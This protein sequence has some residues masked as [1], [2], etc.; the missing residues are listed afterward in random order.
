MINTDITNLILINL[1]VQKFVECS[2]ISKLFYKA[3]NNQYMW[4]KKLIHD[5]GYKG[6]FTIYKKYY[7][8]YT[9]SN[10]QL[11]FDCFRN[12]KIY[13]RIPQITSDTKYITK[14]YN[15]LFDIHNMSLQCILDDKNCIR[16][17]NITLLLFTKHQI[18]GKATNLIKKITLKTD[19]Q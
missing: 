5:F 6:I 14:Y 8:I 2:S 13:S 9:Q 18:I 4:K 1:P 7:W 12:C 19:G 11:C 10:V 17:K 3:S 15:S 16:I